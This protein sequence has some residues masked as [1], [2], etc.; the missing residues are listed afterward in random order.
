MQ[1]DPFIQAPLN[2]QNYNRYSYV[3]NNP[4]SY[5]DPSGYLFK[6]ASKFVRRYWKIGVAIG[7]TYFTAGAASGW[8][9]TWGSTWYTA[10]TAT[11]TATFTTAGSMAV[12]SIAGAAGG[13]VGGGLATG[14]A[15]GALRGAFTG[16]LSG[17]AGGYA[18]HGELGGWADGARRVG[19][20]AL[21]GCA[22]GKAS[23]GSCGKGARLAAIAQAMS[24]G[25]EKFTTERPAYATASEGHVIKQDPTTYTGTDIWNPCL[26]ICDAATG[27]GGNAYSHVGIANVKNDMPKWLNENGALLG[28]TAKY[29]PGMNSGAVFHDVLVGTSQ[30]A[31]GIWN[32]NQGGYTAVVGRVM[33]NQLT[34]VPAISMNYVALGVNSYKYYYREL[35][36]DD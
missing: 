30:R 31:L 36:R 11:T 19:A 5:T 15:K 24:L 13:F 26:D 8:V 6:K 2:T 35:H 18:G 10:A 22:A 32:T 17:A 28:P 14:N 9:S 1:P 29:I 23:G 4:M 16:A 34:I 12:G 25:I 3:L 7:V 33:T 27:A 21:G 20:S